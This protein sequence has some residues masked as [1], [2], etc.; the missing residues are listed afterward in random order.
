MSP[1]A[2]GT[3]PADQAL[4][5]LKLVLPLK[6]HVPL[7]AR[8]WLQR[9]VPAAAAARIIAECCIKRREADF[10]IFD[11]I[12]LSSSGVLKTLHRLLKGQRRAAESAATHPLR[13]TQAMGKGSDVFHEMQANSRRNCHASFCG[14][15]H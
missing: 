10:R 9:V 4:V 2:F 3:T 14:Q 8:T 15:P 5:S 1:T 11:S 7:A 6:V 12:M 13:S